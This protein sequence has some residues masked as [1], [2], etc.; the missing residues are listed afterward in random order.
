MPKPALDGN[1]MRQLVGRAMIAN[2]TAREALHLVVNGSTTKEEETKLVL[3]AVTA[4]ADNLDA[5][6]EINRIIGYYKR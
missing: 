1:V 6:Q 4:L 5:L 3:R 2:R